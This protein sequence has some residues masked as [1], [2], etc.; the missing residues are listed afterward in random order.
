LVAAIKLKSKCNFGVATI[1]FYTLKMT[2]IKIA[3]L[4]RPT[5]TYN[6]RTLH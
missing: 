1:L 6:F 3:Y 4:Q 5:T 2:L